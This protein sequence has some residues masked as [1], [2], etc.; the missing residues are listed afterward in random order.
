MPTNKKPN[1]ATRR[2]IHHAPRRRN[3]ITPGCPNSAERGGYHECGQCMGLVDDHLTPRFNDNSPNEPDYE[4][5]FGL[6]L[7]AR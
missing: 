5:A 2:T 1:W 4:Q 3:C 6:L 7:A